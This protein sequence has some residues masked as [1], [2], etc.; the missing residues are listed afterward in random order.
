MLS[1]KPSTQPRTSLKALRTERSLT[2]AEVARAIGTSDIQIRR[3]E[4]GV[5]TPSPFYTR[6]LA[7]YY[8]IELQDFIALLHQQE[9]PS[10]YTQPREQ[11]EVM[12]MDEALI[13]ESDRSN[14]QYL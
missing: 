13:V 8:K 2:Q 12:Q 3:W 4:Q 14:T 5:C 10:T 1:Q 11:D 7:D 6:Q 9:T